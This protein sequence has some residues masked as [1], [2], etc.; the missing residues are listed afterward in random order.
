M[1]TYH[2]LCVRNSFK[3]LLEKIME[4]RS[5]FTEIEYKDGKKEQR[6]AFDTPYIKEP[7][8]FLLNTL[9]NSYL[10]DQKDILKFIMKHRMDK[11]GWHGFGEVE[12][13]KMKRVTDV[14]VENPF[15][16][17]QITNGRK[18]FYKFIIEHDKRRNKNFLKVFP[19]Y[20]DFFELCKNE[21]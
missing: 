15:T 14:M 8:W 11:I 18:D 19:E 13:E 16:E 5:E 2:N 3:L 12:Y 20:R 6:I 17:E 10:H 4:W 9:P 1:C 21:N 7:P